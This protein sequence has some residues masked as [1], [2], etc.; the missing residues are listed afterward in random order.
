MGGVN[1]LRGGVKGGLF[2]D[3]AGV[4]VCEGVISGGDECGRR[5]GGGGRF[6]W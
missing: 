1:T 2:G 5:G 3:V 4:K 6:W